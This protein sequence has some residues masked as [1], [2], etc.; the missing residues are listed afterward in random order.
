MQVASEGMGTVNPGLVPAR[1][2]LALPCIGLVAHAYLYV[3]AAPR[4]SAGRGGHTV[5]WGCAVAAT[6]PNLLLISVSCSPA[7]VYD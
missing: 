6:Q 2:P 7:R 1:V 4:Q 5:P 3:H